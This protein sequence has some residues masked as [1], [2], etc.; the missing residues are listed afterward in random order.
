MNKHFCILFSILALWLFMP[1]GPALALPDENQCETAEICT[2]CALPTPCSACTPGRQCQKCIPG[3]PCVVLHEKNDPFNPEDGP[4]ILGRNRNK[5]DPGDMTCDA[6]FKNQIYARA[7]LEAE[8]ENVMTEHLVRKPDS[9]MEYTCFDREVAKSGREAGPLFTESK[10]WAFKTVP[11]IDGSVTV[12]VFMGEDKL[13]YTLEKLIIAGLE[14]YVAVNFWH[15]FLG[16]YAK[17][18]DY[19]KTENPERPIVGKGGCDYMYSIYY[20]A[21]CDDM[22]TDEEFFTFAF[23]AGNDPRRLPPG[24]EC[25]GTQITQDLIDLA[26]NKGGKY[27]FFD[28]MRYIDKAKKLTYTDFMDPEECQDPV[29]TGL[30]AVVTRKNIDIFSDVT[31]T[32]QSGYEEKTCIDPGCYY[33]PKK[34]ECRL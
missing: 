7:F 9:I 6:D 17:G 8:R 28:A 5:V 4:N 11:T 12:N 23:L 2:D 3:V 32:S 13:D 34:G 22:I 10:N 27:A 15:D 29:P 31:T 19:W 16:G 33:D 26:E 30:K 24:Q 18:F 14:R 25:E 20:W 1:G 21:K